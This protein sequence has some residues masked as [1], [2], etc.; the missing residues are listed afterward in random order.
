LVRKMWWLPQAAG[1]G[2][3]VF[4]GVHNLGVVK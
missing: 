1:S 3:S 4:A 2:F